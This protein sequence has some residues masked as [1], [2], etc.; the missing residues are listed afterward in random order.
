MVDSSMLKTLP[1]GQKALEEFPRFGLDAF[2]ERF[3]HTFDIALEVGGA[4]IEP[5][6]VTD[7]FARLPRHQQTSDFHCVTTWSVQ[8][9]VW[10]GVLFRD[11]YAA[12]LA[13]SG[14]LSGAP[15]YV[16]FRC[17]DGFR[18]QLPLADLLADDVLLADHL[19]GERLTVAH[20]APLRLVAPAH[21]GYKSAK[22]VNRIEF[23]P[24]ATHFKA[25]ALAF[26]DHPNA[27]VALEERGR[28]FPGWLLRIVYRPL[29][30]S[31]IS[32]FQRALV[33]RGSDSR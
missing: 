22:H 1:P 28:I 19:N 13:E 4:L 20:G 5:L 16:L 12:L 23:W 3:P 33:K 32:K 8:N 24:D 6:V 15:K 26:M 30:R 27:R 18:A 2:A 11:F 25:P 29:V 21:Y 31:T 7:D 9:L 14:L 10:E 17:Q